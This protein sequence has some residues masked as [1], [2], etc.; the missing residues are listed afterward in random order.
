MHAGERADGRQSSHTVDPTTAHSVSR[1][2]NR[3][4]VMARVDRP[5]LKKVHTPVQKIDK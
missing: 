2:L 4:T 1:T 3:A 5:S